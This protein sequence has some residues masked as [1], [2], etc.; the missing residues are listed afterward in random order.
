MDASTSLDGVLVGGPRY[1]LHSRNRAGGGES[2]RTQSHAQG[3]IGY[4][5]NEKAGDG[6]W[7]MNKFDQL[8]GDWK[9][10]MTAQYG[11]APDLGWFTEKEDDDGD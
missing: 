11:P 6:G 2:R 3:G 4:H 8:L 5:R 1:H 7:E 9:T 10:V